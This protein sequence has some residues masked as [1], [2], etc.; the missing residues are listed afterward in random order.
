MVSCSSVTALVFGEAERALGIGACKEPL[1][2]A[3]LY[4]M[5]RPDVRTVGQ[6]MV[7]PARYGGG[8]AFGPQSVGPPL[9]KWREALTRP[10][11]PRPPKRS[12]VRG[13][14]TN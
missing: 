8:P 11:D 3:R 6:G 14:L 12:A 5:R 2:R 1:A 9:T 10:L 4:D 13:H 7:S